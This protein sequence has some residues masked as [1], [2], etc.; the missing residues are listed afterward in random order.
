LQ[1]TV[2][3][4]A[5]PP[6]EYEPFPEDPP[7]QPVP[8]THEPE[9]PQDDG[10]A[11]EHE[12]PAPRRY[13]SGEPKEES[14]STGAFA[15]ILLGY[16]AFVT[17]V[18][19]FFAFQYFTGGNQKDRYD[20]VPDV[21]GQYEKANRRQVSLKGLPDPKGELPPDLLVKLGGELV[22]GDLQVKPLAVE[23]RERLTR[24]VKKPAEGDQERPLGAQTLVLSLRVKNLSADTTFHPNDPAFNRAFDKAD[25]LPYTA[26]VFR[27]EFQY[28]PLPW[29]T[30]AANDDDYVDGFGLQKDAP[31]LAP[32]AEADVFVAVAPRG[33]RQDVN[34]FGSNV[35]SREGWERL[36]A[37]EPFLWR[38]QLRRGLVKAGLEGNPV[39]ISATA[40]IGVSFTRAD[41]K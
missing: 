2:G 21:Y 33:T 1:E 7:Y 27:N 28:G 10:A 39:E 41:V 9:P 17:I 22:V 11:S 30:D 13:P 40:V 38:V 34:N 37:T 18:A 26:L 35:A 15:W 32:G 8:E 12:E 14:A 3:I 16:G 25:P 20:I 19:G 23:R 36:P 4:T 29:P 31:P 24:I 6:P 5:G